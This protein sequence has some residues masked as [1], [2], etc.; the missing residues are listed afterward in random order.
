MKN[1]IL[2]LMKL[3]LIQS[4]LIIISL[5][6]N[7]INAQNTIVSSDI[8]NPVFEVGKLNG[9]PAKPEENLIKSEFSVLSAEGTTIQVKKK[10]D[11]PQ[12]LQAGQRIALFFDG[13]DNKN[14]YIYISVGAHYSRVKKKVPELAVIFNDKPVWQHKIQNN[15]LLITSVIPSTYIDENSN[16]LQIRNHGSEPVC[17]DWFKIDDIEPKRNMNLVASEVDNIPFPERNIFQMGLVDVDFMSLDG[18]LKLPE[19]IKDFK[20]ETDS[21]SSIEERREK[22]S[23]LKGK[24]AKVVIENKDYYKPLLALFKEISNTLNCGKEPVI[25]LYGQPT[26]NQIKMLS[27]IFGG[28][29]YYWVFQ[30]KQNNSDAIRNLNKYLPNANIITRSGLD[31]TALLYPTFRMSFPKN[32]IAGITVQSSW[33]DLPELWGGWA[34]HDTIRDYSEDRLKKRTVSFPAHVNKWL[35]SGGDSIIMTSIADGGYFFD[36]LTGKPLITFSALKRI[37]ELFEGSPEKLICN[38]TPTVKDDFLGETYWTAV[39]NTNGIVTIQ[40]TSDRER[41][42][43]V[44]LI[45]P[46]PFSGDV[47]CLITTGYAPVNGKADSTPENLKTDKKIITISP[48]SENNSSGIFKYDF[49]LS[50]CTTFRLKTKK[51]LMPVQT[52]DLLAGRKRTTQKQFRKGILKVVKHDMPSTDIRKLARTPGGVLGGLPTN[53]SEIFGKPT[54]KMT[55]K[56]YGGQ[57]EYKATPSIIG[58]VNNVVPWS[59][60]STLV[61]VSFPEGKKPSTS[62]GVRLYFGYAPANYREISFWVYPTSKNPIKRATLQFYSISYKGSKKDFLATD[63]K[64]DIWQRVIMPLDKVPFPHDICIVGNPILPEYRKGNEV[65]FEFNGFS[66]VSDP[67]KSFSYRVITKKDSKEL[68]S[69]TVLFFGKPGTIGNFRHRFEKPVKIKTAEFIPSQKKE[70]KVKLLSYKDYIQKKYFIKIEKGKP[71]PPRSKGFQSTL[72]Y[73]KDAQLFDTQFKFPELDKE[74]DSKLKIPENI[75]KLLTEKERKKIGQGLIPIGLFIEF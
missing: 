5:T 50:S 31:K 13:L 44:Q 34:Y 8:F 51:S 16:I 55:S 63:L 7:N 18:A 22:L 65:S 46:V 49:E 33:N 37:A 62:E 56:G 27:A 28:T 10:K 52:K 38:L 35:W 61:S 70:D 66:F 1:R 75:L 42:K 14:H 3:F 68:K 64:P 9:K 11:F 30:V 71:P 57:R 6:S 45:C 59:S 32:A 4:A 74:N 15:R 20:I 2:T 72:L 25:L 23:E 26:D 12:T 29:V 24:I 73:H 54:K 17:F 67:D 69:M 21:K 41:D 58:G 39:K 36:E 40:V 43:P 19:F 60:K 53:F 47:E 48:I